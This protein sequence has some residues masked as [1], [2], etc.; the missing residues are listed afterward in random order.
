MNIREFNMQ[1]LRDPDL[2]LGDEFRMPKIS[3]AVQETSAAKGTGFL[4]LLEESLGEVNETHVAADNA[5]KDLIA[6]RNKNI[7][8][9][10]LALQKAD[11]SLKSMMQVRNKVLEAYKE[12]M[13]MQI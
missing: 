4:E 13:K 9:T 2:K 10:M 12:V 3:D 5:V 8:E 1:Q 6:G 7:H 11:L